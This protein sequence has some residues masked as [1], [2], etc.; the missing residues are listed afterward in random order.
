MTSIVGLFLVL[1]TIL[2]GYVIEKTGRKKLNIFGFI[3]S[4]LTMGLLAV[5]SYLELSSI[6]AL[7]LITL[8]I[9]SYGLA[10]GAVGK[11]L[12][13]DILPDTGLS[14]AKAFFWLW[15]ILTSYGFPYITNNYSITHSFIIFS[16]ASLFSIIF[17]FFLMV[18]TKGKS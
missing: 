4:C 1:S 13:V 16:I 11:I 2:C 12:M 18:E 14:I 7:V 5:A 10:I 6:Y 15:I 9:M 8:Y 17:N 3:L